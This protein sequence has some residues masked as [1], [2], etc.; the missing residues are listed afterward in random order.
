MRRRAKFAYGALVGAMMATAPPA[1]AAEVA[2]STW[3]RCQTYDPETGE[4]HIDALCFFDALVERYRRLDAYADVADLRQVMRRVGE[5]PHAVE[6]RIGVEVEDGRLN[7]KTPASEWRAGIARGLRGSA[8]AAALKQRR[9]LWLAPHMALKFTEE[10]VRHFRSGVDEGFTATD[11]HT[12]RVGER[13]MVH[14]E[15]RSSGNEDTDPTATFDLY[16]N[17]ESMLVEKI[18]GQQ[19]LPDGAEF[20][21]TLDITPIF[22]RTTPRPDP[23]ESGE[24]TG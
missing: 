13:S 20:E 11:A 23:N 22:S 6:T 18:T 12:V 17:P 7:V 10:P 16:V 1:H 5:T 2:G 24:P 4:P 8:A 21:T 3:E 9:D 19:R 14:L 15:L